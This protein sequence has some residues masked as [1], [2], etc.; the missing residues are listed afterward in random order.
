MTLTASP[1]TDEAYSY[2]VA[3]ELSTGGSY[4]VGRPKYNATLSLLRL[5]IDGNVKV[6]TYYDKVDSQAWEVVFSIFD[7]N[8]F[9]ENECRLP[10]RCG[11]LGVCED[12][13]CV[14]CPSEKGLLGWSK[15]CAAKKV[16][17]CKPSDFHYYKVQGVD[18]FL[19]N[20]NRGS[21]VSESDCGKKCTSDCKCLGYFYNRDSSRCWIAYDLMTLAK[22][23]NST[24]VGYI[25]TPNK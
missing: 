10:E 21:A 23:A 24:H 2:N 11:A 19:S 15:S 12:N 25:K 14:A 1:E 6:Y 4:F 7:V 16:T 20:Y 17:S 8:E 9:W 13:Q 22:V 3:L 5:G 18:H